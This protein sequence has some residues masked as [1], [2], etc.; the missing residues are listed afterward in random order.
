M[1]A[2]KMTTGITEVSWEHKNVQ[3]RLTDVGGQRNQR[4]KW[5]HCFQ[6]VN[7]VLFVA[8]INEYDMQVRMEPTEWHIPRLIYW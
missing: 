1:K 5:I 3:F 6:G 4:A 8:A 2:R 7:A